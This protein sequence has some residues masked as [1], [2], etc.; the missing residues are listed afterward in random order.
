[1]KFAVLGAGSLGLLVSGYLSKAGHRVVVVGKPEQA[2]LL[3]ERGI[4]VLAPTGFRVSVETATR[5]E[6]VESADYL[7]VAVKTRDT[8]SALERVAGAEFGAVLSLQNGMAKDG[9]LAGRFGWP[10]VIGCATI[11]GATLVGP[12][13]TQHTMFGATYLGEMDGSRSERVIGLNAAFNEA[14][15]KAE[16]PESIVSAE[17]SST[18]RY[19]RAEISP[20]CLSASRTSVHQWLGRAGS[21]WATSRASRSVPS[22]MPPTRRP[23]R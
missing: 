14:G 7:L 11:L 21:R 13:R 12:G 18:T 17:W 23:W 15:L 8:L 9:L 1:L 19:A 4:E 10:L 20:N 16:I 6:E 22:L 3:R 5:A 2:I